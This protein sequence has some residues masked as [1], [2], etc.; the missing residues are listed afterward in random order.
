M[1][2]AIFV[3]CAWSWVCLVGSVVLERMQ[4]QFTLNSLLEELNSDQ[5]LLIWNCNV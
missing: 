5:M 4:G 3:R 1:K 2:K